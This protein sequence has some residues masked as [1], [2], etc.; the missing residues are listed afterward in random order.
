[1][2]ELY[3]LDSNVYIHAL[4]DAA[5]LAR[6][7]RFMLR[8]GTRLRMSAVVALELRAGA[9]TAAQERAV[10]T[11]LAPYALRE[12]IMLPSFDAFLQAGRVIAAL[13]TRERMAVAAGSFTNDVI[14]ASACRESDVV[15]VTENL[16][17]FAAIQR[18][19]RGFRFDDPGKLLS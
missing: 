10:E 7:K 12:R 14:L 15:L 6:L 17:D 1:V 4:R 18:H 16:R 13:A 8:V 9:R 3:T 2:A 19:L 5:A 11:L